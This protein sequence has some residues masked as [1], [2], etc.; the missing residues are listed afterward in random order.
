MLTLYSVVYIINLKVTN[1]K[2]DFWSGLQI[3]SSIRLSKFKFLRIEVFVIHFRGEE[4]NDHL[5]T[6]EKSLA[7]VIW[8]LNLLHTCCLSYTFI[9]PQTCSPNPNVFSCIKYSFAFMD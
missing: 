4:R 8:K 1:I 6:R 7:A 2:N 9:N 5:F 3:H